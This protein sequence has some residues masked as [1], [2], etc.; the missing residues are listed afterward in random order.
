[1]PGRAPS[2]QSEHLLLRDQ[3][4]GDRR[5]ELIL[6]LVVLDEDL[7][8]PAVDAP[9][10]VDLLQSHRVGLLELVAERG[11]GT[12]YRLRRADLDRL[13]R[14]RGRNQETNGRQNRGNEFAH[15]VL[16]LLQS[17]RPPLQ[18]VGVV[19]PA[20][21]F[22]RARASVWGRLS[23]EFRAST[24]PRSNAAL[25]VIAPADRRSPWR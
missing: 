17:N 6:G 3:L 15:H 10:R 1:L 14:R 20:F 13:R 19:K 12:G 11:V 4:F 22:S 5:R 2:G 16:L 9:R 25:R 18:S 7:Q 24:P 8:L 23:R 21:P